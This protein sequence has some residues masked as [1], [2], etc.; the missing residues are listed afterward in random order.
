MHLFKVEI[1]EK[2]NNS[3]TPLNSQTL[4]NIT[5]VDVTKARVEGI[6]ILHA[7]HNRVGCI[8]EERERLTS[9]C[10]GKVLIDYL[11]FHDEV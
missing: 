5:L 6:L 8:V 7:A 11:L 1:T 9:Q 4:C 3:A 10:H 2:K